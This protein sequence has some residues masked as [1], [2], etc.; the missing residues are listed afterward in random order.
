MVGDNLDEVLVLV[1]VKEFL[2][3]KGMDFVKVVFI[4]E[5]Y[6]WK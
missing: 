5:V 2:G 4:K 6:V 1:K 3:L